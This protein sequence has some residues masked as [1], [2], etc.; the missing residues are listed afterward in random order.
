M[1]EPWIEGLIPALADVFVPTSNSEHSE[2]LHID[3]PDL[4]DT[5]QQD[6][7]NISSTSI[8]ELNNT[9]SHTL[10]THTESH[11]LETHIESHTIEAHTESHT[12]ET[13]TESHTLET[14]DQLKN[15]VLPVEKSHNTSVVTSVDIL[16]NDIHVD[17]KLSLVKQEIEDSLLTNTVPTSLNYS[18]SDFESALRGSLDES[19][20]V[21]S[22]SIPALQPPFIN[23]EFSQVS[24]GY[25]S[26]HIF[27]F[28]IIQVDVPQEFPFVESV[29]GAT[30]T[31]CLV[32]MATVSNRR[33]LT[34]H[35]AQ[36]KTLELQLC[37]EDVRMCVCMYVS[38][39]MYVCNHYVSMYMCNTMYVCVYEYTLSLV[40]I[41]ST[42]FSNV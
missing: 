4:E 31:H 17:L 35:D 3:P 25:L 13:H 16:S 41:A 14:H 27:L 32:S 36:K 40:L 24:L 10:E 2:V 39:Y 23:I 9:K 33:L 11:A 21:K 1:V 37:W 20:Q 29:R 28:I 8:E 18:F 15:A 5:D 34:N 42:K 7:L 30:M 19:Y 6:T 38:M 22:F 12:I 26:F